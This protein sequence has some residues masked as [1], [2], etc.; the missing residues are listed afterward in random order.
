MVGGCYARG[1]RM[2][3]DWKKEHSFFQ[4]FLWILSY[5]CLP[6]AYVRSTTLKTSQ[7]GLSLS[8]VSFPISSSCHLYRELWQSFSTHWRCPCLP[9]SN[10]I[11]LGLLSGTPFLPTSCPSFSLAPSAAVPQPASGSSPSL[12]QV[13]A[14]CLFLCR[15]SHCI[16]LLL[17]SF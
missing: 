8:S 17:A 15:G 12:S 9:T 10:S 5:H 16:L 7:S 11:H 2:F 14:V 6:G 13:P 1:K 4:G 3:K